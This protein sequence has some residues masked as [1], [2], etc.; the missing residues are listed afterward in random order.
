[1]FA[2]LCMVLV[3]LPENG[4]NH[5]DSVMKNRQAEWWNG[6]T[7]SSWVNKAWIQKHLEE[8]E[9]VS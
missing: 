9:A 3:S 5:R 6:F 8:C 2:V 4:N 1:M 7:R